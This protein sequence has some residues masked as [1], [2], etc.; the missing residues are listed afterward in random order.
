MPG[1]PE[2]PGPPPRPLPRRRPAVPGDHRLGGRVDHRNRPPPAHGVGPAVAA[3]RRRAASTRASNK[4]TSP[5][6]SGCHCT[7][8]TNPCPVELGRLDDPVVAAGRDPQAA[9]QVV[10]GLVV[11]APDLHPVAT[12]PAHLAVGLGGHH[13]PAEVTGRAWWTSEPVVSGRCCTKS[14]PR[15]TFNT[16]RPRQTA[17]TG[18]PPSKAR[19][20]SSSSSRSRSS[21]RPGGAQLAVL[22]V[23]TGADVAP[24]DQHQ[25]VEPL[26]DHVEVGL[27]LPL[28]GGMSTGCPPARP[29]TSR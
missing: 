21:L 18:R 29:T 23:P 17:R 5:G 19:R 27:G 11:V 22:A 13:D 2:P 3:R 24:A 6:S 7:P 1:R 25:A 10:D 9:T 14:P 28:G 26:A 4:R 20:R 15:A 16:W 12:E 8:T